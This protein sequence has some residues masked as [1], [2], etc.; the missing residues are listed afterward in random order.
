MQYQT[1]RYEL[2]GTNVQSLR[3]TKIPVEINSVLKHFN[4][5]N[6]CHIHLMIIDKYGIKT[7]STNKFNRNLNIFVCF[8]WAKNFAC[9]QKRIRY[10]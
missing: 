9:D 7:K 2:S 8:A 10:N 1:I 4:T 6:F 5:L 3:G